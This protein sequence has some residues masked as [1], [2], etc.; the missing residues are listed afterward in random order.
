[1]SEDEI[2]DPYE[3]I[4]DDTKTQLRRVKALSSA[5]EKKIA[6]AKTDEEKQAA[7][8]EGLTTLWKEFSGTGLSLLADIASLTKDLDEGLTGVE[9]TIDQI[10]GADAD[11][12]DDDNEEDDDVSEEDYDEVDETGSSQLEK[13]HAETITFLLNAFKSMLETAISQPALD[14][15]Q[16]AELSSLVDVCAKTLK[17]VDDMTLEELD[18]DEEDEED[19]EDS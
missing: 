4:V 19:D 9:E 16:K 18:E 11:E 2:I 1:M 3:S 7:L 8:T 14:P 17:L 12:D 15:Q 5:F 10:A 13:E 6:D